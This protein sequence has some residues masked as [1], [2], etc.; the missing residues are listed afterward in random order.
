LKNGYRVAAKGNQGSADSKDA[1]PLARC[2]ASLIREKAYDS[3]SVKG[4]LDRA[5]V[6]RSTLM[7]ANH[8]RLL[9]GTPEF[10]R[11]S[12]AHKK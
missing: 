1:S 5:N 6:G 11:S 10:E 8:A 7:H 4:I 2:L 3:I 12:N 9:K